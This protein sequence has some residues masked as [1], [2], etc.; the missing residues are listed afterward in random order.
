MD[1]NERNDR[2]KN[3]LAAALIKAME[4][5][6]ISKISIQ[7]LTDTCG[8]RRQTFYYHFPDIYSLLEWIL[9]RD[10][11]LFNSEQTKLLCWQ[12]Y[13]LMLLKFMDK[14][15]KRYVSI[16]NCVGCRFVERFYRGELSGVIEKAV[17]YYFAGH[18]T[19]AKYVAFLCAYFTSSLTSL[20]GRWVVGELDCT[21][22]EIV[23]YL[24]TMVRDTVRGAEM[25]LAGASSGE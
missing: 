9:D 12:E 5:K 19:N 21:P 7:E 17:A 3:A 18:R 2:T 8:I 24:D 20:I 25:R 15:K 23:S 14:N 10:R 1:I 22:E 13:V 4:N 6:P 16:V 11:A